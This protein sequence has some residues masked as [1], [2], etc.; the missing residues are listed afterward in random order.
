M[1]IGI[2]RSIPDGTQEACQIKSLSLGGQVSISAAR[3]TD[4]GS[5]TVVLT[6]VGRVM[7]AHGQVK[8]GMADVD[9][10][11]EAEGEATAITIVTA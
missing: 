7:A 5:S 3:V 6:S 1:C 9:D 4:I 11:E 10:T 8:E 2:S